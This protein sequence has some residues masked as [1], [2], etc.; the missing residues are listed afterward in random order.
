MAS[1][2]ESCTDGWW[3][4]PR[5]LAA[6]V[7]AMIDRARLACFTASEY[8]ARP[9][10]DVAKCLCVPVRRS[11]QWAVGSGQFAIA[12][13]VR[14]SNAASSANAC[15]CTQRRAQCFFC[16]GVVLRPLPAVLQ[17]RQGQWSS[18]SHVPPRSRL[19]GAVLAGCQQQA[20]WSSQPSRSVISTQPAT[21]AVPVLR[22]LPLTLPFFDSSTALFAQLIAP[23][24]TRLILSVL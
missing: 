18:L 21:Q 17:R 1:R 11:S 22:P 15:T 2:C 7:R 12:A 9:R 10:N 4:R 3:F 14:T 23:I 24:C 6:A 16:W 13:N 5:L 8:L 19:A 20:C